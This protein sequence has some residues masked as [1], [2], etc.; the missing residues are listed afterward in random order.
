[1]V[2]LSDEDLFTLPATFHGRALWQTWSE[3]PGRHYWVAIRLWHPS[4]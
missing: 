3:Q 1:M 2:T 4:L